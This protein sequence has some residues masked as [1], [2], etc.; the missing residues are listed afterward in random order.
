MIEYQLKP[1]VSFFHVSFIRK[2]EF[3]NVTPFN[4]V[5]NMD[6]D[7]PKLF[8]LKIDKFHLI[9]LIQQMSLILQQVSLVV[10]TLL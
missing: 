4:T 5:Q 2:H 9:Y 1:N 6:P 10:L 8:T 3:F 7:S